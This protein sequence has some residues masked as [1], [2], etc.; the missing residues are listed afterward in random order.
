MN[1]IFHTWNT[2]PILSLFL[3]ILLLLGFYQIGKIIFYNKS[4]RNIFTEVSD[5]KYQYIIISVNFIL[6]ISY[7]ITLFFGL[8]TKYYLILLSVIVLILGV[9]KLVTLLLKLKYLE[10]SIKKNINIFLSSLRY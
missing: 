1:N 10:F 8:L 5:I 4:L 3:S 2:I 9:Y 7:P 6:I